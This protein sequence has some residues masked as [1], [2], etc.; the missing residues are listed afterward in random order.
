MSKRQR[1]GVQ[2]KK[3]KT[4][5]EENL[6]SN[7]FFEARDVTYER[8]PKSIRSTRHVRFSYIYFSVAAN[9]DLP[10]E[11]VRIYITSHEDHINKIIKIKK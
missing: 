10:S 9:F 2:K 3:K 11:N 6:F 1:T 8:T 7:R 4:E 5:E